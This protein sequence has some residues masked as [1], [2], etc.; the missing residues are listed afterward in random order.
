MNIQNI[1]LIGIFV[2][3]AVLLL[4]PYIAM[5]FTDEVKW[6]AID[7]VAAGVLL[8]GTGLACELVLRTV[9]KLQHR[10]AICAAILLVLFI[11]WAELAVGLIGTPLAGS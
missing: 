7:F 3:V 9:K 1:R 8:L 11:V 2:A 5:K 4:I 6:T 10:L